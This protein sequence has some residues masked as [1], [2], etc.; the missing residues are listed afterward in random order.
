[1]ATTGWN[2]PF[3][4]YVVRDSFNRADTIASTVGGVILLL[5]SHIVGIEGTKLLSSNEWT[6]SIQIVV[7]GFLAIWIVIMLCRACWWPLHWRLEP[8]DGLLSFLRAK[9][10]TFMW[11]VILTASGF[12]AFVLLTGVGTIWL[13]IQ[14]LN[15]T[16]LANQSD[17]PNTVGNPDFA[18][19]VPQGRYRFTWPATNLMAFYLRL[20][21][22]RNPSISN[23]PAFV[24]RNRTNTVAYRVSATWR[25]ETSMNIE[26]VIKNSPKLSKVQFV[27]NDTSIVILGSVADMPFGNFQYFRDYAP[28]QIIPVIAKEEEVYLPATLWPIA[29][30]YLVDKVPD[31]I[32]E[33]SAPF[34]ALVRLNWETSEGPRERLYRVRITATNA[35]ASTSSLPIVDAFLNFSLEEIAQ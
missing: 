27:I 24:L 22:E 12:I 26:D 35:K 10:G 5:L 2:N 15:G 34:I 6:R 7:A 29:A 1:M 33:T 21:T 28:K 11:P 23:N 32:G 19:F 25:S 13:S 3:F 14:V 8:H 16:T 31:N 4:K 9:L 20:D 18:L 30:I 17:T